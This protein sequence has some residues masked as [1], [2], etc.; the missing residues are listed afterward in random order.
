MPESRRCSR[1]RPGAPVAE[2]SGRRPRPRSNVTQGG[3]SGSIGWCNLMR[4][5]QI[6]NGPGVCVP[7]GHVRGL[8]VSS[9]NA[10]RSG[11]LQFPPQRV[12]RGRA[13][14]F[15]MKPRLSGVSLMGKNCGPCR[16]GTKDNRAPNLI[17]RNHQ[18]LQQADLVE[19]THSRNT[20]ACPARWRRRRTLRPPAGCSSNWTSSRIC[21]PIGRTCGA[22]VR[23]RSRPG[24]ENRGSCGGGGCSKRER[25]SDFWD[26]LW[27][28]RSI[29]SWKW[30][31]KVGG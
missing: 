9:R 13:A 31:G 6:R 12:G 8:R 1:F 15:L 25:V 19:C 16:S 10:L 18:N 21:W 4:I 3:R 23:M 30:V 11:D 14:G 5:R 26:G 22:P 7:V 29:S 27:I 2:T 17:A 28:A 20:T 24:R